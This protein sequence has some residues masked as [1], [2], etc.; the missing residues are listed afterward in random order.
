MLVNRI[1]DA[2]SILCGPKGRL[3]EAIIVSYMPC[4]SIRSS[5]WSSMEIRVHHPLVYQVCKWRSRLSII[6]RPTSVI[7]DGS[8]SRLSRPLVRVKYKL[9][10]GELMFVMRATW[11]RIADNDWRCP[12]CCTVCKVFSYVEITHHWMDWM[13]TLRTIGW[14]PEELRLIPQ[15]RQLSFWKVV[16]ERIRRL[17][18]WRFTLNKLRFSLTDATRI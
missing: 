14:S 1:D 7:G 3:Q 8:Y 5:S 15:N 17:I 11:P 10:V 16:I 6:L 9:L 2:S 4:R 18:W 12:L 13:V